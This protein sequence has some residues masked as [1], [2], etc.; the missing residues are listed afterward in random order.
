MN[1]LQWFFVLAPL[2]AVSSLGAFVVPMV[3]R[4]R[5]SLFLSHFLLCCFLIVTGQL[6]ELTSSVPDSILL[7]SR[8]TYGVIAILPVFWFLLSLELTGAWK[9]RIRFLAGLLSVIPITTFAVAWTDPVHHL[10]WKERAFQQIGN[11]TVNI[12]V[13][14]GPW[15]W[16]H[17]VYSYGLFF[18]GSVLI[19]RAYARNNALYRKQALW[20][21]AGAIFP[22]AFS[23]IYVFRLLG[24]MPKDFSPLVLV[25]SGIFF[26]MGISR[27]SLG[28]IHL[29]SRPGF[30][31]WVNDAILVLDV[32]KRIVDIN[33]AAID[34]LSLPAALYLG[35]PL[36]SVIPSLTLDFPAAEDLERT[37]SIQWSLGDSRVFM[38][39]LRVQALTKDRENDPIGYRVAFEDVSISDER[40]PKHRVDCCLT[41]TRKEEQVLALVNRDLSNKEIAQQ[42]RVTESAVKAHV[43][44]LLKK[45][46]VSHRRELRWFGVD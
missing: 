11:L 42:L 45:A 22:V 28:K 39:K 25:L 17:C 9:S 4:S 26:T 6:L 15:F 14:Y 20:I 16:V 1:S 24:P 2:A 7:F 35:R 19:I 44:N 31:K 5:K 13:Q 18:A 34:K 29:L 10:L 23:L 37:I 8:L 27:H 32:E 12:V 38:G 40:P 46:D 41:L 33:K 21:L 43:H 36:T 3:R 30:Y